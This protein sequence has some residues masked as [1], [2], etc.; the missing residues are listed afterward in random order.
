MSS[1]DT[2]EPEDAITAAHEA[3]VGRIRSDAEA[4]EV[5]RAFREMKAREP[6]L[7]L[8]VTV[9]EDAADD[10]AERSRRP[11]AFA[12][13]KARET[14]PRPLGRAAVGAALG[15]ATDPRLETELL[16][17]DTKPIPLAP[18]VRGAEPRPLEGE[19]TELRA[20][21]GAVSQWRIA[22]FFIGLLA[23]I[24][25]VLAI[26]LRGDAGANEVTT[27]SGT[28]ARASTPRSPSS[29]TTGP[30]TAAPA[31]PSVF[32]PPVPSM[33]ATASATGSLSSIPSLVTPPTT[34]PPVRSSGVEPPTSATAPKPP[35]TV[36]SS[37]K[38]PYNIYDPIPDR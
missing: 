18:A 5:L 29:S 1:Q 12:S 7:P 28:S 31:A 15:R 17:K 33:S 36:S 26:T 3:A 19:P 37:S 2:K 24:G 38:L 20:R 13:R 35:P 21:P 14:K 6:V 27:T 34:S 4:E 23:L 9:L 10:L 16:S 25:V 32:A 30:S 22:G 8:P 11:A